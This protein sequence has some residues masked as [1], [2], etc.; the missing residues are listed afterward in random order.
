MLRMQKNE[1]GRMALHSSKES[2]HSMAVHS[3]TL[4]YSCSVCCSEYCSEF[5]VVCVAVGA[6]HGVPVPTHCIECKACVRHTRA[7]L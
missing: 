3:L 1:V 2:L 6:S 4:H 5:V 7:P